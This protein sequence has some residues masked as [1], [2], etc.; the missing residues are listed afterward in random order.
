MKIQFL[1]LWSTGGG[2]Y[3]EKDDLW[4]LKGITSNTKQN[5]KAENPTCNDAS[6]AV[7]TDVHK[8][9]NRIDGKI[10]R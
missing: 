9:I 3:V 2:L 1:A 7:F 4:I 10:K 6:F 5:T 8:F